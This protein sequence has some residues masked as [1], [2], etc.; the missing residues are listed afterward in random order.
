[1]KANFIFRSILTLAL[2]IPLTGCIFLSTT[3]GEDKWSVGMVNDNSIVIRRRA[4]KN[5]EGKEEA[6][7]NAEL[8]LNQGLLDVLTGANSQDDPADPSSR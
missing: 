2:L 4:M 7:S 1:M 5:S 3:A 6:S 8:R